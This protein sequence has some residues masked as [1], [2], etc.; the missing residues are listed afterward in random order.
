MSRKLLVS[1][2]FIGPVISIANGY[3]CY[4]EVFHFIRLAETSQWRK[5]FW[6][7]LV[8]S[9]A[10][11]TLVFCVVDG[12]HIADEAFNPEG[13]I[14]TV[15][16]TLLGF[17]IGV[18]ALI[19]TMQGDFID[20]LITASEKSGTKTIAPEMFPP[21]M[22]YPLSIYSLSILVAAVLTA[23]PDSTGTKFLA[24]FLAVYCIYLTLV[25]LSAIFATTTFVVKVRRDNYKKEQAALKAK[26][27]EQ[28]R[29]SE[30]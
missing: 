21:D 28:K 10:L 30:S 27:D 3:A 26:S 15:F 14:L 20:A 13:L 22:A 23:I 29:S 17:G 19:F 16:P 12:Q 24:F 5:R 4:G 25:L 2:P 18:F 7:G 9:L 8:S 1:L 11:T 6:K